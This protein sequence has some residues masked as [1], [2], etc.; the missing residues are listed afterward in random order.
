MW[1]DPSTIEVS[2][3]DGV[4]TLDGT[5]E[6]RNTKQTLTGLVQ[7][8]DGVVA[9]NDNLTFRGEHRPSGPPGELVGFGFGRERLT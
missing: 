5:V 1:I 3:N 9:L 6:T 4:V 7:R 2:V 8:V